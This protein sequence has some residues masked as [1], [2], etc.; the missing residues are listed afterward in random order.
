MRQVGA[1]HEQ[2]A[3]IEHGVDDG[4]NLFGRGVPHEQGNEP[5]VP[6]H[7]LEEGKLDFQGMLRRVRA[8]INRDEACL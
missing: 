1:D 8:I 2:G 3:L 6:E 7:G 4:G 5:E